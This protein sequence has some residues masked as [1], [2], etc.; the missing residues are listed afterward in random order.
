[1][2]NERK[3]DPVIIVGAGPAGLLAALVLERHGQTPFVLLERATP[4]KICSNSGSGFDLAPTSMSIMK[5]RLGLSIE[6][7]FPRY[8]KIHVGNM[9][10]GVVVRQ[11]PIDAEEYGAS[12]STMQHFFLEALLGEK[13]WK[14]MHTE[15]SQTTRRRT[16]S[17][18]GE[19]RC[20]AGVTGY[21]ESD[22]NVTV[23]LEDGS[24]IVGSVVLACDGIHSSIR[25]QMVKAFL[26]EDEEDMYHYCNINCYWGKTELQQ[27]SELHHIF[28]DYAKKSLMVM[29]GSSTHPGSFYMV[30]TERSQVFNWA[31]CLHGDA[32]PKKSSDDLT[33]RGGFVL[34]DKDKEDLQGIVQ[35][36]SPLIKRIIEETPAHNMTNVG[37]YDRDNL[38]LPYST[39]KRIALLGDAAH[40]QTPF[41]GQGW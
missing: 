35:N 17:S 31:L 4:S 40:P 33:R 20:G 11:A 30:P 9:G 14:Q 3:E 21:E 36:Y 13:N 6:A 25:R 32:P 38:D 39:N 29:L 1:M 16:Q 7:A 8:E 19:L 22:E 41:M 24:E 5:E 10:D 12:R 34:D 18:M 37:L 23:K 26:K 28:P 27:G 15:Q 2:I